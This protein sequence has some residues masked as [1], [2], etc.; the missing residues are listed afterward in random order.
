MSG[1]KGGARALILLS[2]AQVKDYNGTRVRVSCQMTRVNKCFDIRFCKK[3][4]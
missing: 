4:F 1:W 2:V 3:L